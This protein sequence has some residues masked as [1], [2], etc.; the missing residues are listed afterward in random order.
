MI[1]LILIA[2][3]L[4]GAAVALLGRALALPRVQSADR[5]EDIKAYGFR[6]PTSAPVGKVVKPPPG[7]ALAHWIGNRLAPR[8]GVVRERD[9][10]ETLLAA[11]MYQTAPRLVLGYRVFATVG[12]IAFGWLLAASLHPVLG[13][14][15]IAYFGIMGWVLPI[16]LLRRR[17]TTRLKEIDRGLPDLIDLLVVTVEAGL[18]FSAS[19]QI[20]AAR[21]HGPIAAEVR[22]ALQEQQM[23]LSTRDSLE[24]MLKRADTPAMRSFVRSII[25]GET[26]GVPIGAIMRNLAD[27]MRKRRRAAAEELAQKAPTKI[28]FPLV[29]LILPSILI[30]LLGPAVFSLAGVLGSGS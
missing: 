23:G 19:L 12:L 7:A 11:G 30:V 6:A 1:L 13:I 21:L 20:A 17:A 29:F 8:F 14:M 18:G 25:Q 27:E 28:L 15:M 5:L 9:L 22:L 3:C 24:N 4:A 16:T 26:L 10:R 2:A